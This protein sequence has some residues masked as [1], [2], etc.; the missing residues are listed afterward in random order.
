MEEKKKGLLKTYCNTVDLGGDTYVNRTIVNALLDDGYEVI[1]KPVFD[2]H[3][4]L[5]SE[6]IDIYKITEKA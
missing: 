4:Q 5:V 2:K 6:I 3:H 1:I